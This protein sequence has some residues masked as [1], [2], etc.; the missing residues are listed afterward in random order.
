[1]EGFVGIRIHI[2]GN[3]ADTIIQARMNM[4]DKEFRKMVIQNYS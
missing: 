2:V 3:D 4:P 1:M